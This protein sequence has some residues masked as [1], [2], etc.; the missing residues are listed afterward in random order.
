M[1]KLQDW[2]RKRWFGEMVAMGDQRK[3][4]SSN[5]P[6]LYV[7]VRDDLLPPLHQGIQ[8][9]HA[10]VLLAALIPVNPE[11]YLIA[12]GAGSSDIAELVGLLSNKK[13]WATYV[14][15]GLVEPGSGL[16]LLTACAFEPMSLEEGTLYFG[17][18][19]RAS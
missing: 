18:L 16:P 11:S 7:L 4:D 15:T 5:I 13:V 14:D 1:N 12:L 8:I 2:Q 3:T 9:A 6:R 17:H 10:C 19:S